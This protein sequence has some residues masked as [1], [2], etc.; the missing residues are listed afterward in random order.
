MRLEGET[1]ELDCCEL[2]LF[3]RPRFF[4]SS[5]IRGQHHHVRTVEVAAAA[6]AA[7]H[8]RRHATFAAV[9]RSVPMMMSPHF[10]FQLSRS[11]SVTIP[12]T[13]TSFF[14][15]V[16]RWDFLLL[17]IVLFTRYFF[18]SS[19]RKDEMEPSGY[20]FC[21][22]FVNGYFAVIFSEGISFDKLNS[23]Y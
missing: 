21:N 2:Q 17:E 7:H 1:L 13:L 11:K 22:F 15:C 19:A 12:S 23:N 14:V 10:L 4:F 3:L 20:P 9:V 16:C 6:H 5:T 18:N 8:R